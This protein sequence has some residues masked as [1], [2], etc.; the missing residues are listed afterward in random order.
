MIAVLA[1]RCV[2]EDAGVSGRRSALTAGGTRNGQA[3]SPASNMAEETV[4]IPNVIGEDMRTSSQ[5]G[6]PTRRMIPAMYDMR[7][8]LA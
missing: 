4:L 6:K 2:G 5:S 8:S 7:V 1:G 3:N